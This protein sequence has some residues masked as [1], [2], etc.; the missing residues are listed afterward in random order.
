MKLH[1]NPLLRPAS[2][3]AIALTLGTAGTL[4]LD[5][6]H[7]GSAT[8]TNGGG[9]NVLNTLE[10]WSDGG[11]PI[12]SGDT[13]TWDGTATGILALTYNASFGASPLGTAIDI[14]SSQ[15]ESLS[16]GCTLVGTIHAF[17]VSN[18]TIAANAG[19]FTF[20]N[21]TG[22][23]RLTFRGTNTLT[24]DSANTATFAS[25]V[26]FFS[27]GGGGRTLTFGGSGNWQVDAGLTS[28]PEVVEAST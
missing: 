24:N 8:W 16:I 12:L 28:A 18:I 20:G 23:D 6:A 26:V 27:G 9:T 1:S 4:F 11:P 22:N 2:L 3:A 17:S 14:T 19:A 21:G 25:D 13:A 5:S 7:A 10:N 15:A